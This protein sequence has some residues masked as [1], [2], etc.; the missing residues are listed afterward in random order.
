TD[1]GQLLAEVRTNFMN[2]S[3]EI[4]VARPNRR[5]KPL[6]YAMET[7]VT[8]F[9]EKLGLR[10]ADLLVLMESEAHFETPEAQHKRHKS[11]AVGGSLA[12][13][14]VLLL[15][16]SA[17]FWESWP[18][19]EFTPDWRRYSILVAD[20]RTREVLFCSARKFPGEDARSPDALKGK[21]RDTLSEL[22]QLPK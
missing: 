7:N 5:G 2:L 4:R 6:E 14:A 16:V 3:E 19:V 22:A 11:N 18:G 17:G 1:T 8:A 13:L 10:E 20:A 12:P 9:R 15:P 21:L